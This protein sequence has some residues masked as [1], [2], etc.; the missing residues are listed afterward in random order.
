[1]DALPEVAT[2]DFF[3]PGGRSK[4]ELRCSQIKSKMARPVKAL[5]SVCHSMRLPETRGGL[6]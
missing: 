5:L 4:E 2:C 6:L 3:G 1:V